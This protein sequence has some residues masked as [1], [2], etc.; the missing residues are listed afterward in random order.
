MPLSLKDNFELAAQAVAYARKIIKKGSTQIENNSLSSDEYDELFDF[1]K[2]HREFMR[3]QL[4]ISESSRIISNE[5]LYRYEKLVALSTAYGLGNCFELSLQAFDFLLSNPKASDTNVEIFDI[6]GSDHIFIV[7]GRDPKSDPNDPMSWG[8]NAVICDPWSSQVYKASEYLTEL[9]GFKRTFDDSERALNTLEDFDPTKHQLVTGKG[10][11]YSAAEIRIL[12]DKNIPEV[13]DIF[14]IKA[15]YLLDK[16]PAYKNKL[17]RCQLQNK[18]AIISES[19]ENLDKMENSLRQKI[20]ELNNFRSTTPDF[21]TLSTALYDLLERTQRAITPTSQ[22]QDILKKYDAIMKY[23][24]LAFFSR[25]APSKPVIEQPV[26][27][28]FSQPIPLH[29]S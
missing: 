8:K 13:I 11:N 3:S 5:R 12:K 15:A 24:K 27:I 14:K 4:Q 2:E 10:N 6:K 26:S 1:V 18:T 19:I 21:R 17:I 9:K 7:I 23:P 28:V 20:K 22:V 29:R 16:I 25:Q